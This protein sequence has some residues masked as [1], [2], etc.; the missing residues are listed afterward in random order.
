MTTYMLSTHRG[1]KEVSHTL[2]LELQRIVSRHVDMGTRPGPSVRAACALG[3]RNSI[4]TF[5][6][7]IDLYRNEFLPYVCLI[8][9]LRD[10]P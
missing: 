2:K 4:T 9:K 1:K 6:R 7:R 3:E 5:Q 8:Y 10:S